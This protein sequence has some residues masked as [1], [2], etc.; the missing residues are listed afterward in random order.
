[1]KLSELNY[2]LASFR[3][4]DPEVA[5]MVSWLHAFTLVA[6]RE[7]LSVGELAHRAGMSPAAMGKALAACCEVNRHGAP[8]L[9]LIVQRESNASARVVESFLSGKG[10]AWLGK[11]GVAGIDPT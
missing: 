1:M 7:G 9:G 5:T 6:S 2:T 11:I 3:A 8:G 10:K 4:I